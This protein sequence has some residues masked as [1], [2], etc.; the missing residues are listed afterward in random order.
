MF[1][2]LQKLLN[3]VVMQLDQVTSLNKTRTE[4]EQRPSRRSYLRNTFLPKHLTSRSE[5][6]LIENTFKSSE[7]KQRIVYTMSIVHTTGGATGTSASETGTD[8]AT[9]DTEYFLHGTL[10]YGIAIAVVILAIILFIVL[11]KKCCRKARYENVNSKEEA[12]VQTG[13][14]NDIQTPYP[15]ADDCGQSVTEFGA[16]EVSLKDKLTARHRYKVNHQTGDEYDRIRFINETMKT[17][18]TDNNCVDEVRLPKCKDKTPK[19]HIYDHLQTSKQG[20]YDIVKL[21]HKNNQKR[22]QV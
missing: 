6:Q 16:T 12:I 7:T 13:K 4:N 17:C 3:K 19:L 8:G 5:A 20:G 18:E 10:L 15:E 22:S 14:S 2:M 1:K 9:P 11:L 21:H